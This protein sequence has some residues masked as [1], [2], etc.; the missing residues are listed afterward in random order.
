MAFGSKV[1]KRGLIEAVIGTASPFHCFR[2]PKEV[3]VFYSKLLHMLKSQGFLLKIITTYS[4]E[5]GTF[6]S[7]TIRLFHLVSRSEPLL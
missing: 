4:I 2:R 7:L 3:G 6:L 1:P 5:S